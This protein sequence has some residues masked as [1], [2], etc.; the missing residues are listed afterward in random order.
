MSLVALGR[1]NLLLLVA[2]GFL[3]AFFLGFGL[4]PSAVYIIASVLVVPS[5]IFLDFSP[6]VA[7]FFVFLAAAIS[8]F[9][10]P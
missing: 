4:P 6:W 1:E 2:L 8:E 10:P 5:F 3:L 9:T 7:H